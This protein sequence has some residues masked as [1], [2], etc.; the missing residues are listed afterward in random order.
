MEI[1]NMLPMDKIM[2]DELTFH[3]DEVSIITRENPELFSEEDEIYMGDNPDIFGVFIGKDSPIMETIL[4]AIEN[5]TPG[6]SNITY[7]KI[8]SFVNEGDN[9]NLGDLDDD[10]NLILDSNIRLEA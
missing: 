9:Y 5:Y 4:E 1:V 7:N 3:T 6:D 10:D 8:H 2:S